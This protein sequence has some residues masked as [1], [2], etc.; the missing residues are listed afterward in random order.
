MRP[1]FIVGTQ[2]DIG[3]TTTSIG[4]L[5]A[6]RDRGLTV[7]YS[8]PL[9]QRIRGSAGHILHDDAMLVASFL[10]REFDQDLDTP[11]PLPAGRVEREVY[12]LD[13]QALLGRVQELCRRL[14]A[15]YDAVI[16]ESMGHVA[17]GSCLGLSSADVARGLGARVLLVS[18]GGIGRAIDEISLC[19]TFLTAKGADVIGVVLN[20]VWPE[21]YE[22]VKRATTQGLMNLGIR[23]LGAIPYE[24]VLSSPTVEQVHGVVGG[25]LIAGEAHLGCRVNKTI[26]AAMRTS[27]MVRYIERGTLVITP[28]DRTDNIHATLRTE[29]R[30]D[31]GS[32]AVAGL[33]LTGGL[34]PD[35]SLRRLIDEAGVPVIL[36]EEDTYAVAS[37]LRETVFKVTPE[38]H[39]RLERASRIIGEYVDVDAIL[40]ELKA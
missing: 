13:T 40:A 18:G 39:E 19:W 29:A 38:D 3:K 9:G 14:A 27:H 15:T 16:L 5:S 12:Q 28:G 33:I 11:V 7:G 26:V 31:P 10:G 34:E 20:K 24:P 6:F 21:K 30:R 36:V 17:M 22:R 8:K 23:S 35:E 1:L 37:S 4:L 32:H 2:R 25:R